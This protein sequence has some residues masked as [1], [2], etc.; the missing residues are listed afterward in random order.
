TFDSGS[1]VTVTA[2][3]ANCY[4]FTNW[5]E[6]GSVV[7]TSPN[8]TFTATANRTL[9]ANFTKTTYSVAASASPTGGGTISGSGNFNC[10][11]T[12]TVAA[13]PANCYTF[14]TWTEDGTVVSTSSS[15]SFT[16][17]SNRSF[18]THVTKHTFHTAPSAW[19]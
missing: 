13:T 1:S 2:S 10:G 3:A 9:V 19:P 18:V 7:S 4:S 5:T 14:A 17:K 16:L 15:Y 11:S 12:V 6:N 8:Y